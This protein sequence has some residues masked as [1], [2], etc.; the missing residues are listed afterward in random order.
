MA[1]ILD[2]ITVG[3]T[4]II[5]TDVDPSLGLGTPAPIG[6]IVI[7]NDG[8]GTFYKSSAGDTDWIKNTITKI[9]TLT[10]GPTISIDGSAG[11][12]YNVVIAGNRT[13]LNP[14][15][16]IDGKKIIIKVTQ[17]GV[18]GRTLTLDTAYKLGTDISALNLSNTPNATDYI[19]FVY[20]IA[21]GKWC[22]LALM[23]GF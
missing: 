1:V 11:S 15:N 3:N 8:S 12:Q 2:T 5:N 17:D 23:R 7:A 6:A 18:G 21:L 14:T 22:L 13:L 20:D 19:G 16:P 10:D 9:V 4:P